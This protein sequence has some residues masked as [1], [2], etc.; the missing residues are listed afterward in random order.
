VGVWSVGVAQEVTI[1]GAKGVAGHRP[2]RL[3]AR[4]QGGAEAGAFSAT[5]LVIGAGEIK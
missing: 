3:D 5:E 1:F 2:E 4:S